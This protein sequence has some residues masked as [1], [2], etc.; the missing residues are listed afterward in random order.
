MKGISIVGVS[1]SY[2][3][4][5]VC[6]GGVGEVGVASL[7]A[8]LVG[9]DFWARLRTFG[10]LQLEVT[11]ELRCSPRIPMGS[12][13]RSASPLLRLYPCWPYR[14]APDPR[15]PPAPSPLLPHKNAAGHI[16]LWPKYCTLC[17]YVHSVCYFGRRR[18]GGRVGGEQVPGGGRS[19]W[20]MDEEQ[21][22]QHLKTWKCFRELA[23]AQKLQEANCSPAFWTRPWKWHGYGC[24]RSRD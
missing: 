12:T 24:G 23:L 5:C 20:A 8:K 10:Q 2:V 14:T 13:S 19:W 15:P 21:K 16:K 6:V 3:C 9:H 11:E 4:V 18:K 1:F 17:V 7:V 22:L